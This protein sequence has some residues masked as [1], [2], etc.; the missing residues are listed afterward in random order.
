[1]GIDHFVGRQD[2]VKHLSAVLCGKEEADGRLTVQSIEGPGGIGKTCLFNHVMATTDYT[3][4]NY[5]TLRADGND[6]SALTLVRAVSQMANGAL[7]DAIR[8]KPPGFYFP[9][10]G[11]VTKTIEVIRE[12]ALVEFQNRNPDPEMRSAFVRLLELAFEAGK[13]INAAFPGSKERVNVHELDKA[14]QLLLDQL[15]PTL[16]SLRDEAPGL[17]ELLGLGGSTALRNAI[18]ENACRPLAEALLSDLSAVL[19]GYQKK[20]RFKPTHS[21]IK[22]I[23]RLLLILDD[24]EKLQEPLGEFLVGSFLP[25]LRGAAFQSVVIVIGRDQLE[26]MHTAWDTYLKPNMLKPIVLE[27]LSRPEMDELVEGYGVYARDE[28]ERVWRDTQG[29]PFYVQLWIEEMQSG[30]RT[31]LMLMRFYDRTTRW[32]S[33]RE[34]RWLNHALFLDQVNV[35]TLRGMIGNQE[36]AEEGFNWFEREGSVRDTAGAAFRVREYLRSRLMDYLRVRDPDQ[37]E[38]LQGMGRL[39]MT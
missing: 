9:S 38:K 37:F 20:D 10:V 3:G 11:H 26:A 23:D 21:K 25:A 30:G 29:Y 36:E 2:A 5:L 32:M 7:A 28:K 8:E 6:P 13:R 18:K 16:I 22:G 34:K 14:R 39:A 4:R 27:A 33:E 15:V 17:F 24:Y 35:R 1:M 12:Q 19:A 31:A